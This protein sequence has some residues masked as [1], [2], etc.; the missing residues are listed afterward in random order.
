M[1]SEGR[2][3]RRKEALESTAEMREECAFE[4]GRA[5]L[6]RILKKK[7]KRGEKSEKSKNAGS[8]DVETPGAGEKRT[9][10]IKRRGESASG[11]SRAGPERTFKEREKWG[12]G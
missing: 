8:K 3:Q 12:V 2:E 7:E 4:R 10:S 11:Q 6:G 1:F 9:S 5:L